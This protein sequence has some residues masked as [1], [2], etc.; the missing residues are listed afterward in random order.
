MTSEKDFEPLGTMSVRAACEELIRETAERDGFDYAVALT[1]VRAR[2]GRDDV[3]QESV[4]SGMWQATERLHR[5]GVPGVVNI[6]KGWQRLDP[7][8]MVSYAAQR[9]RRGRRQFRRAVTAVK[10]TDRERL[11]FQDR[12]ALDHLERTAKAVSGLE[13]RRQRRLRPLPPGSEANSA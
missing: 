8:G 7:S 3:T 13:Q 10:A 5:E 1:E 12:H 2:T 9:D 6:G 4:K 11:E